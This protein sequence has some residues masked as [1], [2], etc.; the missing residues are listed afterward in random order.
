MDKCSRCKT[1]ITDNEKENFFGM[2]VNSVEEFKLLRGDRIHIMEI[3]KYLNKLYSEIGDDFARYFDPPA[4]YKIGKQDTTNF[5]FGIFYGKQKRRRFEKL[6]QLDPEKMAASL[7]ARLKVMFESYDHL[8]TFHPMTKDII[9]IVDLGQRIRAD[10]ICVFC[11][12][13]DCGIEALIKRH[14][15]QH[16]DSGAWKLSNFRKHLL[17]H[18]K[19]ADK[20]NDDPPQQNHQIENHLNSSN[21]FVHA[22]H[23]PERNVSPNTPNTPNT[24]NAPDATIIQNTPNEV[25]SLDID[26]M[27]IIICEKSNIV[28]SST[29]YAQFSEQNLKMIESSLTHNEQAKFMRLNV[30]GRF[31]NI[32][33][34]KI[35]DNGNCMFS[36]ITHQL[37]CVEANSAEHQA[38]SDELRQN[39]VAE[40]GENIELYSQA[41]IYRKDFENPK[42]KEGCIEFVSNKLSVK[43]FWGG[44]ET[45]LAV[46]KLHQTNVL[47]F[48]EN[49]PVYFSTGFNS[50]FKRT[51]FLAYRIATIDRNGKPIYNHY[52]SVSGVSEE[53]LYSCAQRLA[54]MM[55]K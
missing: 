10:I 50:E 47:V 52:D 27:P 46:S 4:K 6:Q 26:S 5:Q 53:L 23:T 24:P 33:V 13:N 21:V 44:S 17:L 31:F 37:N 36:S 8:E 40:I 49:G 22:Q 29:L 14:A 1:E 39:V 43:G 32:N 54:N 38:V 28:N 51:I 55:S 2:Y 12:I 30:D 45:L 16:D 41:M 42:T 35:A 3:A 20:K 9:K 11:P 15:I 18:V 7:L 48:N 25:N 34:V 19:N